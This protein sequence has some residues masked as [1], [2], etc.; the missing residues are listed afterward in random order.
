MAEL[1]LWNKFKNLAP[2]S[3]RKELD[4]YAQIDVALS[5]EGLKEA[6]EKVITTPGG[7][8]LNELERRT[9]AIGNKLA[10]TAER[11]NS[12]NRGPM[13]GPRKK[14]Q[15]ELNKLKQQMEQAQLQQKINHIQ[16]L[17]A[18]QV[19]DMTGN[20]AQLSFQEQ[21]QKQ[22]ELQKLQQEVLKMQQNMQEQQKVLENTEGAVKGLQV[23]FVQATVALSAA[24]YAS[25]GLKLDP[26][27]VREN[28]VELLERVQNLG[29]GMS[30]LI[31]D[32]GLNLPSAGNR[33]L[34]TALVDKLGVDAALDQS[35]LTNKAKGV[36]NEFKPIAKKLDIDETDLQKGYDSAISG[37]E[38]AVDALKA[39]AG[40]LETGT[41]SLEKQMLAAFA[42]K[43]GAKA[44]KA[45][46]EERAAS[47]ASAPG[48]RPD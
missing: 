20:K 43:P 37:K 40:D 38:K 33:L 4:S 29:P 10:E 19:K 23:N 45:L 9:Y 25:A 46:D 34:L 30:Q 42:P 12:P 36:L 22:A 1:N 28:Y 8:R 7:G 27:A 16:Q 2:K 26:Q 13:F 14:L 32:N 3:W 31:N 48:M 39:R 47:P 5:S 18:V 6:Y 41:Q 24:A 35:A 44:Q 11:L 17:L 21:Q 15:T